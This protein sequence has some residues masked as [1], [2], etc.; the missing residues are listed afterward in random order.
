M[1]LFLGLLRI[2]VYHDD[3][4]DVCMVQR[5]GNE[6]TKMESMYWKLNKVSVWEQVVDDMYHAALNLKLR[7]EYELHQSDVTIYFIFFV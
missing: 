4:D 5:L 1:F 2:N 6:G 3:D 7:L